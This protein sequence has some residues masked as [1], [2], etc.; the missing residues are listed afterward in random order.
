[1]IRSVR[2]QTLKVN[3]E[4]D[5]QKIVSLRK[6]KNRII[7]VSYLDYDPGFLKFSMFASMV[8]E[9]GLENMQT[10]ILRRLRQNE[11][12]KQNNS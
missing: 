1:M 4:P 2:I 9:F 6:N 7:G 8:V 10:V 5:T 11:S 12:C 3:F